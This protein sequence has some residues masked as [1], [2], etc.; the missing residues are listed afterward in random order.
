MSK[1]K[2]NQAREPDCDGAVA[3]VPWHRWETPYGAD[4]ALKRG[5]AFPTLD[6]PLAK[7]GRAEFDDDHR[8]RALRAVQA[9]DFAALDIRL[10]LNTH[11]DCAGA[12]AGLAECLK[13][14]REARAA[15][16]REAGPLG[17]GPEEAGPMRGPWPWERE[18]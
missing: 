4:D 7:P 10:F 5:T 12:R 16:E 9:A 13:R 6:L 1:T 18:A 17:D 11:P 3:Y 2:C 15:Y 8:R 14:R